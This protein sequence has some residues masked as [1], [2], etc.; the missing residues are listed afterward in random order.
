MLPLLVMY[1]FGRALVYLNLI[2]HSFGSYRTCDRVHPP[3]NIAIL[4]IFSELIL[5]S[6]TIPFMRRT[7]VRTGLRYDAL[8]RRLFLLTV[9]RRISEL[10]HTV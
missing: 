6:G 2:L 3:I 8:K 5:L 9:G 1:E 10:M 4:V 7:R